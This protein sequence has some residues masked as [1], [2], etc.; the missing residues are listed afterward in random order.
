MD[1]FGLEGHVSMRCPFCLQYRPYGT[2]SM[3]ACASAYFLVCANCW[4]LCVRRG[5]V[6]DLKM[7]TIERNAASWCSPLWPIECFHREMKR[8]MLEQQW[9]MMLLLKDIVKIGHG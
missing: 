1:S 5:R 3:E 6:V 7:D 9:P 2:P 8:S 4:I